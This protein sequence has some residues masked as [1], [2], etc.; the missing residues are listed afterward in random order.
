MRNY[1]LFFALG[2][3]GL[4]YLLWCGSVFLGFETLL[5]LFFFF[6]V[7]SYYA[8]RSSSSKAESE[9]REDEISICEEHKDGREFDDEINWNWIYRASLQNDRYRGR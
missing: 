7:L 4:T 9:W 3:F 2:P 5:F 1:L 8:L 6:L